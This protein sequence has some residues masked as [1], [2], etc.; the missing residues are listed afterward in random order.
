MKIKTISRSSDAYVPV[1]NTE[2]SA[3]PRNLNPALHPFERAREYTK[4]LTAT[5]LERMFAQPFIGQLGKSHRDGVYTLAKNF[6][7]VNRVAS[8]SGD[9]VIKYWDLTSRDEIVSFKA[10]Y[11]MV[12][13]LCV[14]PSQ[15]LLSCGDDKTI[16]MWNINNETMYGQ[17]L[18]DD[19]ETKVS[20]QGLVKTYLGEHSFKTIDH[21]RE[22]DVF[23]T[24]GRR[25]NLWDVNR[26]SP[27]SDLSWGADNIVSVKFN[28]SE[29]SVI[30]ST[31]SDNS[32][33]LYDIRTNSPTQKVRTSMRSNALCWNPIEPF[34]FVSAS[35]DHNCYLWDMR[36]LSRSSNIYKDHV[37]AV[38]DVDFS[39]TGQ[40]LV[41]GSYDKTI[42]I[43]ETTKGHSRDIYHTKRMQH[44]FV[45]KFSMD[46][47][48]ILS[49]SDDGNVRLWRS[50]A[51]ERSGVK[52]SRLKTRL[53]YDDKL[54]EKFAALPEVRRIARHRHLSQ[55]IKSAQEIK[56]T[57][58]QS[59]KRREENERKH[60][61]PGTVVTKPEKEKH[62]VGTVH[63]K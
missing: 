40:E 59:L 63:K 41:T 31:G 26:K 21:H 43:Y 57:E 28:M 11:G 5:K 20:S 16:K 55:V 15:K 44:V 47:K 2:E 48:Y 49:G 27:V 35:E 12:S 37:S 24:G 56:R 7:I 8:G 30:A 14:T 54:K 45:T 42:R 50:R 9:G 25:I 29:T 53:H 52:S 32:I 36:N 6:K 4:A 18:T 19:Q 38:M 58:L 46:S 34:S 10:H 1:R 51:S 39:P 22:N 23:V 60:S 3:I 13:G 61:K 62:I 33:V 17:N